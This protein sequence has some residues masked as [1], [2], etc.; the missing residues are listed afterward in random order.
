MSD[1]MEA[2]AAREYLAR[3]DEVGAATARIARRQAARH[4]L[5]MGVA[6]ALAVLATGL[7]GLV[8]AERGGLR[9]LLAALVWGSVFGGAVAVVNNRHVRVAHARRTAVPLAAASAVIVGLT[10]AIGPEY[11]VAYPIGGLLAFAGWAL[12]AAWVRR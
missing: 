2:G 12:G 8:G 3:V 10:M 9:A 7:I 5:A 4:L 6:M 1:Q 11:A